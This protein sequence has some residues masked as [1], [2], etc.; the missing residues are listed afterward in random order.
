MPNLV[1]FDEKVRSLPAVSDAARG[2]LI[3]GVDATASREP[4]WQT[5]KVEQAKMFAS[6]TGVSMQLVYYRG[7]DDFGDTAECQH[8]GWTGNSA[9]LKALMDKVGCRHGAT[10]IE[11]I[12]R[13]AAAVNKKHPVAGLM[14]VG[15]ACEE[16]DV[17]IIHAAKVSGVRCFMF[18]EGQ[19]SRVE[20]IFRAVADVTSGAYAR[21]GSVG[22][23]AMGDL[24]KTVAQY[25]TGRITPASGAPT[26]ALPKA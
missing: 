10:Q 4:T 25:A 24:M 22:G 17:T 12:L 8:S 7:S 2:R 19:D 16:S 3:F 9:R 14:F 26:Y 23:P 11:R 20:S 18:Q 1:P 6:V 21:F 5:A 13:H 15:D